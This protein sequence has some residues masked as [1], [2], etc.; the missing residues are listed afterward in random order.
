MFIIITIY[1]RIENHV[2]IPTYHTVVWIIFLNSTFYISKKD[3][4][5]VFGLCKVSKLKVANAVFTATQMK[6]PSLSELN[7][8]ISY[9]KLFL[10]IMATPLACVFES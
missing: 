4:L 6:F 5:S 9:L 8:I 1:F 7:A 3:G 2:E 10:K